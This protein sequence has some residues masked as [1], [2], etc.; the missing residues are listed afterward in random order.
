MESLTNSERVLHG[1]L[2]C[3]TFVTGL[4]DA[5]SYVA[6]GHVFTANMT[7]NIVFMG[8]AC[9]GVPGLSIE[10]SAIAL[11]F[12]LLGGLLA[13]KLDSSLERQRRNT[14]LAVAFGFETVLLFA[15]M[16]VSWCFEPHGGD[17]YPIALYGIIALTALGMG[18]R[19]GSVRRAAVP[20]LTTT[21]LTLT[22]T[23]L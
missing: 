10:R 4:V 2:Y 20:E 22:V 8:F 11:G 21:V 7:G 17:R 3:L 13:G 14:W 12:A 18:M 15:A 9:G 5:G 16:S 1:S 23:A 19:I 6:M